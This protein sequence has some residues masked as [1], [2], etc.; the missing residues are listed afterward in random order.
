MCFV[1]EQSDKTK[2]KIAGISCRYYVGTEDL[3]PNPVN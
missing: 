2:Q 3:I 1:N